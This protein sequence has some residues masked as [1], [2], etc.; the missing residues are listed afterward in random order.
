MTVSLA[1]ISS[2]RSFQVRLAV[3]ADAVSDATGFSPEQCRSAILRVNSGKSPLLPYS[4]RGFYYGIPVAASR[5]FQKVKKVL[6][7]FPHFVVHG[8]KGSIILPTL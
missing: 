1:S 2:V 6:D 8:K 5:G 3:A 7:S 4:L